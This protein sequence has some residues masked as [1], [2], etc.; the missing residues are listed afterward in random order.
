MGEPAE[1][2]SCNAVAGLDPEEGVAT[3]S[4]GSTASVYV[5]VGENRGF[6]AVDSNTD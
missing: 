4:D 2:V 1:M 3:L 6:D 5:S